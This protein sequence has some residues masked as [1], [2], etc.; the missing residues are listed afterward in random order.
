MRGGRVR[1]ARKTRKYGKV[2]LERKWWVL[3]QPPFSPSRKR[4][5][6]TQG[7]IRREG[8][9]PYSEDNPGKSRN[10]EKSGGF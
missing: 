1:Y 8:K 4:E 2:E 10:E 6:I 7:K 3:V 9:P 5:A